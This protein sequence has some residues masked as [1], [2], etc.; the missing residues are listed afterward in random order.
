[1]HQIVDKKSPV[2]RPNLRILQLRV[3]KKRKK[4]MPNLHN[5]NKYV[6]ITHCHIVAVKI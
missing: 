5:R 1:M 6:K 4:N 3:K 2:M